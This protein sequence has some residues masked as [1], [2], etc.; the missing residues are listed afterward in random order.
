MSALMLLCIIAAFVILKQTET[1]PTSPQNLSIKQESSAKHQNHGSK[2]IQVQ[3]NDGAKYNV[4]ERAALQVQHYKQGTGLIINIHMT[5]HGGTRVCCTIGNSRDG[6]AQSRACNRPTENDGNDIE[7]PERIPWLYT[8]TAKNVKLIRKHFHMIGMEFGYI[9]HV[10]RPSLAVTHGE[11]PDLLSISRH[12]T[13]HESI[14][15]SRRMAS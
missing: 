7:F 4:T 8:Q 11:H 14:A 2:L 5:H 12:E 1:D 6:T 10:P 3:A 13:P 9:G 15:G